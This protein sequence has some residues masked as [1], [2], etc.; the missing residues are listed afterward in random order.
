M[1]TLN[2]YCVAA[3]LAVLAFVENGESLRCWSCSSD[4]GNLCADYFNSTQFSRL[5][6]FY[7]NN[8][9]YQNYPVL[10]TCETQGSTYPYNQNGRAVCMK[11][12]QTNYGRTSYIRQCH[13]LQPGEQVGKCAQE[14]TPRDVTIDFCELCD[15]DG[16]NGAT[17]IKTTMFWIALLPLMGALM[18]TK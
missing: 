2:I 10:Q 15:V 16:C 7:S 8:Q 14:T 9:N 5:S 1:T 6:S 18:L 11:K 12:K 3:I 13:F 4:T 17:S